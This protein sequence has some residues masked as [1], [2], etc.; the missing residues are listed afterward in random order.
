MKTLF[1]ALCMALCGAVCMAQQKDSTK[2]YKLE[3]VGDLVDFI[4]QQGP[5]TAFVEVIRD[6]RCIDTAEFWT[7]VW[8]VRR[9]SSFDYEVSELGKYTFRVA[10]PGYKTKYVDFSI[11]KFHKNEQYRYLPTIYL[12]KEQQMDEVELDEVTVT[13]TRLKFYMNGDTLVYDAQAFN[14]AEGSMLDALIKKLPGVEMN[15]SGQISVNGRQVDELQ[16]NG[17]ELIGQDK[18]LFLQNLPAFMVKNIGVS[19]QT[20][21][22]AR[23][24]SKEKTAPKEIVMNVKLKREYAKGWI[25]NMEAGV[26]ASMY[27]V[28]KFKADR[29]MGR[30]FMS[31]FSDRG[32]LSFFGNA[33]NL[34]DRRNPGEQG[35]WTPLQQSTGLLESY[36]VGMSAS[37]KNTEDTKNYSGTTTFGYSEATDHTTNNG[38][39]FLDGGNTFSR[40][41]NSRTSYN[42]EVK[43]E[44]QIRYQEHKKPVL[45]IFKSFYTYLMPEFKYRKFCNNSSSASAILDSDVREQ[46]GKQW[47]DSIMN[48]MSGD[49]LRHYSINRTINRSHGEGHD[50]K[51]NINGGLNFRPRYN[52]KL[53]FSVHTYGYYSNQATPD[54]NHYNLEFPKGISDAAQKLN[55]YNDNFY[56]NMNAN[57]GTSVYYTLDDDDHHSLTYNYS[58]AYSKKESNRSLYQLHYLDGFSDFSHPI[59]YLPSEVELMTTLDINNSEYSDTR[60]HTHRN[61]LGYNYDFWNDKGLYMSFQAS[62]EHNIENE[63][64]DYHKSSVDTV[65]DRRL[66]YLYPGFYI[67]GSNYKE[68]L[69]FRASYN[70]YKNMPNIGYLMDIVD[71]SNP[72]YIRRGNPNL[73]NSTYHSFRVVYEDRYKGRFQFSSSLNGNVNKNANA[74][75]TVYDRATG[76]STVTPINVNGN[77]NIDGNA[78]ISIPIDSTQKYVIGYRTR[79]SYTNSVD[80]TSTTDTPLRQEVGT[81]VL[82]NTLTFDLKF[83][84]DFQLGFK[85]SMDYRN[86]SSENVNFQTLNVY[87][88]NYGVSLQ[89]KMPWKIQLSGDLTMYSRRGYS[90]SYMNTNELVLN[91]RLSRPIFKGNF[92]LSVDAFD[93]LHNLTNIRYYVNAQGRSEEITNVIPSYALVRLAYKFKGKNKE[94]KED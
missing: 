64:I 3:V 55:R 17:Q 89:Y 94:K 86:S 56:K 13:A 29:F 7:Q 18:E 36:F 58:L 79:Y 48:P 61:S 26:G 67:Y 41:V 60:N 38:E 62:L 33:N 34:N 47:V 37:K 8:D 71:N 32:R 49:I 4:S 73:D 69:R 28:E 12:Q 23:G 65:V 19:E 68:G 10:V 6:G 15:S 35:D 70:I 91:A 20:P 51:A 82:G 43:S 85:G 42:Y 66:Q 2:T 21:K 1:L 72:L 22:D 52:D 88:F 57:L 44:H 84:S 54:F 81:N 77:W 45:G 24:T 74:M 27:D 39:S 16:L 75:A 25:G 46:W 83:S 90:D 93:L 87:D 53:S 50:L 5:D 78:G 40:S 92:V 30:V 11:E 9:H 31:R 63:D 14:M 80:Y 59:G 76:I